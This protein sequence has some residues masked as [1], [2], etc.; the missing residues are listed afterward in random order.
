MDLKTVLL[1]IANIFLAVMFLF[2]GISK[3]LP[4][5]AFELQ[6]VSEGIFN[7][8]TAT[9]FS[10]LL[11][12]FE[13]SLGIMLLIRY[14]MKFVTYPVSFLIL[15]AF[16]I[17]LIINLI[18]NGNS[19][20]CGCF[21]DLMPMTTVESIFKNLFLMGIIV[22]LFFKDKG[23]AL[24]ND[25][26]PAAIFVLITAVL[27]IIFPRAEQ[28]KPVNT[29]VFTEVVTADTSAKINIKDSL[30]IDS[31][32]NLN[33][34]KEAT[35]SDESK[36]VTKPVLSTVYP[37]T[38]SIY[39]VFNSLPE[40]DLNSGIKIVSVLSLDCDHC[41]EAAKKI[42]NLRST[43]TINDIYFLFFG[44]EEQVPEFF[45]NAGGTFNY[46][47]ITPQ[48]FFPLLKKSPP[49]VSLLANGNMVV[50]TEGENAKIDELI[51]KYKQLIILY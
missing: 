11:I 30:N 20:N 15:F 2:S 8:S 34:N 37:K 21:G 36:T 18:V 35:H 27:F 32:K 12:G 19:S 41:M 48:R 1:L 29:P 3:L 31:G 43:E 38:E 17:Y 13:L 44:S 49:R 9:L 45:L 39:S 40:I 16:T 6:L 46:Q 4:V 5:E 42:N 22:V 50:D 24:T 14:R 51:M 28:V 7:W 33:S 23:K 26:L 25:Y 47:I 10:R